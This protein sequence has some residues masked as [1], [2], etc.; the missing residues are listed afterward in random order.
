MR[1]VKSNP[2]Y[3]RLEEPSEYEIG[4]LKGILAY[5]NLNTQYLYTQARRNK[6]QY[7]RDPE[8]W[9][10]HVL[11][12]KSQI[13]QTA[14]FEDDFGYYTF[15]GILTKLEGLKL[16]D[17]YEDQVQAPPPKLLPWDIKYQPIKLYPYQ[18]EAIQKLLDIPHSAIEL[19]TGSGKTEVIKA[20]C[21]NMGLRTV[22]VTPFTAIAKQMYNDFVEAF[23]KKYVG[24][25]GDGKKQHDKQIVI[26]IAAS[27]SKL[28]KNNPAYDSF[29]K[30]D[31][32]IVD[33]SHLIGAPTL[34][35]I[36][37]TLCK[38]IP[39]RWS[40]SAT[41]MR[42]NGTDL[43]LQGLINDIV[44]RKEFKELCDLGYLSPLKF[45]IFNIGS[46]ANYTGTNPL[47]IKQEHYLYNP[48]VIQLAAEIANMRV[49]MG[50][51]V[52]VLIDELEQVDMLKNYLTTPYQVASS[53]TDV[54][55]QV[56]DFNQ[57]LI[58]LLIGTSAVA[59]GANFKPVET[60]ILLME[61][62][63]EIRYKQALGRAT[64]LYPG[65]KFCS[66]IDF[67]VE[68][69]YQLRNHFEDRHQ[70]YQ[71]LTDDITFLD[72]EDA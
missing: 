38:D 68:N 69:V 16:V 3:I 36:L 46:D 20:L 11:K 52:L 37:L 26:S 5:K 40:V 13:D 55:Q 35:E 45:R 54:A 1:V 31:V 21:K 7:N 22:I 28:D 50:E 6:F 14:L 64:R 58:P 18:E 10:A 29:T 65:K 30:R 44:Y 56:E 49:K 15:A 24:L 32:L 43:L 47:K 60:L 59:T 41:Q 66:V 33:E 57:K 61:G 12:L 51:S 4:L 25:Y 53:Q 17:S 62:K 72:A 70:I 2:T 27:L 71:T 34:A 48:K 8:R 23:G 42:N 9:H 67:C 63:S 19:P 39:Y